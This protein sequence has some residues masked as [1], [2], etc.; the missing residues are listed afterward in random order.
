MELK[1]TGKK[2]QQ[3]EYRYS[4]L[5]QKIAVD[6]ERNESVMNTIDGFSKCQGRN[7]IVAMFY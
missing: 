5:L 6:G 1:I 4:G 2:Q 3:A 7:I